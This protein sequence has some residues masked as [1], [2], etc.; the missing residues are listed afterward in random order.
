MTGGFE[1]TCEGI[2][3]NIGGAQC[4]ERVEIPTELIEAPTQIGGWGFRMGGG[5][6]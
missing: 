5:A 3:Q 1:I 4:F 2:E 6:V